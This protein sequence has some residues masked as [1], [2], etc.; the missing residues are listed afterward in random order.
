MAASVRSFVVGIPLLMLLSSYTL[1]RESPMGLTIDY[2]R[3]S[4]IDGEPAEVAA[5][6]TADLRA[7]MAQ[8]LQFATE[9][10]VQ[11]RNAWLDAQPELSGDAV[12]AWERS[13]TGRATA[14]ITERLAHLLKVAELAERA[15]SEGR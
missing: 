8:S 11:V 4:E 2:D 15:S 13:L 10:R 7:L 12:L 6:S 9:A 1:G 3:P 5:A 14:E